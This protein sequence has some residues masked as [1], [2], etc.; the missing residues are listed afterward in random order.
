M[1]WRYVTQFGIGIL[2]ILSSVIG[3][4]LYADGGIYFDD[5]LVTNDS[6]E[7]MSDDF[8]DGNL[9]YWWYHVMAKPSRAQSHS[10]AYSVH[11]NQLGDSVSLA[12]CAARDFDILNPGIVEMSSWVWLPPVNEQGSEQIHSGAATY[13]LLYSKNSI[14]NFGCL[15][16]LLGED[17]SYRLYLKW[18]ENSTP[19]GSI[20]HSR[21]S[22]IRITPEVWTK[23]SLR[24]DRSTGM[25]SGYIDGTKFAEFAYNQENFTSFRGISYWGY[26]GGNNAPVP[27]PSGLLGLA[28]GLCGLGTMVYRRRK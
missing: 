10:P 24:A 2:I 17:T 28:G 16:G 6:Y 26:L 12:A 1:N 25:V 3:N 11:L 8:N 20:N 5:L 4:P 21:E 18:N 23:L 13:M 22:A 19:N 14:D 9:S 27:E 15:V 7:V